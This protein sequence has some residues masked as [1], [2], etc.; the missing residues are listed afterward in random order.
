MH[1]I[2]HI[3]V[4]GIPLCYVRPWFLG[5][6]IRDGLKIKCEYYSYWYANECAT[7]LLEFVGIPGVDAEH[8]PCNGAIHA[9]VG[10]IHCYELFVSTDGFNQH[11]ESCYRGWCQCLKCQEPFT[12]YAGLCGHYQTHVRDEISRALAKERCEDIPIVVRLGVTDI[13]RQHKLDLP[14]D[15]VGKRYTNHYG[16]TYP[17]SPDLITG[18]QGLCTE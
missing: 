17:L 2:A 6:P 16:D 7:Y 18:E 8:G 9:M 1:Q 12:T 10:C 13:F 4:D 14:A 11:L 5:R 3:T 15:E